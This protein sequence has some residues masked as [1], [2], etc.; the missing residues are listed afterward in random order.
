MDFLDTEG[1]LEDIIGDLN[2]AVDRWIMDTIPEEMAHGWV[3]ATFPDYAIIG[4]GAPD[5]PNVEFWE[6]PY[7]LA[8]DDIVTFG[9]P[10]AL[11]VIGVTEDMVAPDGEVAF[12]TAEKVLAVA[13]ST[14][15]ASKI[16][17]HL[18]ILDHLG[19]EVGDLGAA[20][21]P[22]GGAVGGRNIQGSGGGTG[23]FGDAGSLAGG[24]AL[25]SDRYYNDGVS[26]VQNP[27]GGGAM[28]DPKPVPQWFTGQWYLDENGTLVPT[29]LSQSVRPD[30]YYLGTVTGGQGVPGQ[31]YAE[32]SAPG[33]MST[34][35]VPSQ[36]YA[37]SGNHGDVRDGGPG[38]GVRGKSMK[39]PKMQAAR[40]RL[41][42]RMKKKMGATDAEDV[43]DGG[44]DEDAE[45]KALIDRAYSKGLELLSEVKAGRVLSGR[46]TER[47]LDAFD[48]LGQLLEEAG[49]LPV[50]DEN[51]KYATGE[52][53]MT[54]ET[55]DPLVLEYAQVTGGVEA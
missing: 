54:I 18:M 24:S 15:N 7:S 26:N 38:G 31:G 9:E 39:N 10:S 40:Q 1:S 30:T 49:L 42:D 13:L 35:G 55:V 8:D 4:V 45:K 36:G 11:D 37:E 23:S 53:E 14:K 16:R 6:V 48:Q 51:D 34:P 43:A 28:A 3:E 22:L 29:A 5:M 33:T 27:E 17:R 12:Q 19:V 20:I 41:I 46:S 50:P 21:Q 32:T 25:S 44:V 47:V 52:D 2:E